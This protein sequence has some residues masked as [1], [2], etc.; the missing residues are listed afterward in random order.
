VNTQNIAK[1]FRHI[2]TKS[3]WGKTMAKL[4]EANPRDTRNANYQSNNSEVKF[5]T[6][7][8]SLRNKHSGSSLLQLIAKQSSGRLLSQELLAKSGLKFSKFQPA[9]AQ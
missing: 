8:N 6:S 5:K 3:D 1:K 2:R 9:F 7:L 4:S